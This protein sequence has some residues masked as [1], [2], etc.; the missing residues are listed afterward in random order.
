M[1]PEPTR[2]IREQFHQLLMRHID[3][4]MTPE[5]Q[6]EFDQLVTAF[7]E[8]K[9]EREEFIHL[10]EVLGTMKFKT[11][12]DFIWDQ[13]WLKIYN[14]MERSLAWVLISIGVM[15]LLTFGLFKLIETLLA[16]TQL[17]L[18]VKISIV[19][20]LAGVIILFVSVIREKF[21]LKKHDPYQEVQR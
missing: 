8:L 20:V 16:D 7:P 12:P 17:S 13:H 10:K 6:Q 4:E 11:Q 9:Q 18:L 19:T 14:R 3:G 2:E 21:I 1:K 5:A 15:V